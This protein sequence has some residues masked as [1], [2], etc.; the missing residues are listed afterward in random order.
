MDSKTYRV[1]GMTCR[2]CV[3]SLTRALQDALPDQKIEVTLEGG[4]ARIEGAH[5]PRKVEQTVNDAG[6]TYLG[7]ERP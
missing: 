5:D 3:A 4:L 1:D 2:G 7:P 6:Y